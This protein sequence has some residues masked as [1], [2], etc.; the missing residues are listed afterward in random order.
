M[1]EGYRLPQDISIICMGNSIMNK[2]MQPPI[3]SIEV[4]EKHMGAIAV[5]LLLDRVE[6]EEIENRGGLLHEC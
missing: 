5:N 2:Y 1:T 3:T 6:G 4:P